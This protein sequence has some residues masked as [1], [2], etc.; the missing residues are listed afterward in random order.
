VVSYPPRL[1]DAQVRQVRSLR[2]SGESIGELV[3]GF[4]VS[5]TRFTAGCGRTR[6]SLT[7]V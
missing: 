6:P 4:G 1:T 5:P 2:I 3:A 7:S